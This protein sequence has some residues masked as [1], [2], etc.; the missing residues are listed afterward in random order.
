MEIT[1]NTILIK[2]Q[3]G[4]EETLVARVN[5]S[6]SPLTTA[7]KNTPPSSKPSTTLYP[8]PRLQKYHPEL[9][10]FDSH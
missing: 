5:A 8:T 9:S 6:A 3:P 4:A 7:L 10:T 1:G 2:T